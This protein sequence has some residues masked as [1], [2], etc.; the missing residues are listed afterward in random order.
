LTTNKDI[1]AAVHEQFSQAAQFYSTS[2]VHALGEDLA[3][4]VKVA[5]LTGQ[6]RLLDAGCGAGHTALAFAP[7]VAQVVA[8]DLSDAMLAQVERLAQERGLD[9]IQVQRGDVEK[10]D[11]ADDSFDIVASRYSAHHWPDPQQALHEFSR[12]LN[13]NGQFILSDVVSFDDFTLDTF[14]QAIELLRDPSHV[15]D[16]TISQWQAMFVQAGFNAKL[17]YEWDVWLE[18][19]PWVKRISTPPEYIVAIKKLFDGATQEVL[20]ELQVQD[21]RG[22]AWKGGLIQGQ[23]QH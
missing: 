15:R 19:E 6:E 7:Y 11:F 10:L 20:S 1:K 5:N 2:R 4:M 18:F 14:V 17:C 13:S 8:V 21:D 12:V 9:N 23:I 3:E 16:H 22:F